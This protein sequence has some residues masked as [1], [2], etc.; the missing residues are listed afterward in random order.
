MCCMDHDERIKTNQY[1]RCEEMVL[2]VVL[3]GDDECEER[4]QGGGS[5]AQHSTRGLFLRAQDGAVERVVL[6]CR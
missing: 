2:R 6:G 4:C 3:G 5:G 1:G